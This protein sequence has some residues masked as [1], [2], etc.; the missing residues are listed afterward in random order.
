MVTVNGSPAEGA[1]RLL[2]DFLRENGYDPARI[3]VERNG[4]MLSRSRFGETWLDE[5]DALEIVQFV[6]GG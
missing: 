6:G 4:A 2:L 5:G 1:G 3:A